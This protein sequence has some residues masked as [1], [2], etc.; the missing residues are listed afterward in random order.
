M[1]EHPDF[2]EIDLDP[3]PGPAASVRREPEK[4]SSTPREAPLDDPAADSESE[5]KLA[6]EIEPKAAPASIPSTVESPESLANEAE[7][8]GEAAEPPPKRPAGPPKYLPRITYNE[9]ANP[10]ANVESKNVDSSSAVKAKSDRVEDEKPSVSKK[11]SKSRNDVDPS[12]DGEKK[13]IEATPMI[14]TVEGRRYLRIAVG[15]GL[16]AVLALVILIIVKAAS[17]DDPK[18][19]IAAKSSD[20]GR[21]IADVVADKNRLNIEAKSMYTHAEEVFSRGKEDEAISLL[22]KIVKSYPDTSA[23]ADASKALERR[24]Q[25]MPIFFKGPIVS[26]DRETRGAALPVERA[27]GDDD[28]AAID[29]PPAIVANPSEIPSTNEHTDIQVA[30]VTPKPRRVRISAPLPDAE[31][32]QETGLSLPSA[33]VEPIPLPPGFRRREES[34][35]HESGLPIEI[36]SVIDGASMMLIPGGVF[37]MGRNDGPPEERPA[38]KVRLDPYYIDQHEITIKQYKR[39]LADMARKGETQYILPEGIASNNDA[40]IVSV[41]AGEARAYAAWAGKKLPTEAQWEFAAR[42]TDGRPHPWGDSPADWRRPRPPKRID[43]V[44]SFPTDLSPY[45]VFDLAGNA[46]EWT[47]DW[48]D[49]KLYQQ[50][51]GK[52]LVNPIGAR[53][54]RD[55]ER[56]VKGGSKTY[57]ASWRAGIK[58]DSRIPY[59]GFRCVL[60]LGNGA[61]GGAAP[62]RGPGQPD[63]SNPPI[64]PGAR[65][66]PF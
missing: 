59:L 21:S 50:T 17:P 46:W 52:L 24:E 42:T 40:P 33:D 39:F 54:S 26:A 7:D 20:S 56:T 28:T 47:S 58:E 32:R 15:G 27:I 60:S 8:E 22:E 63:L 34:G 9:P 62:P 16:F 4:S 14:E 30:K 23:A 55:R 2:D 65:Q 10:A 41:T 51:K 44:M 12:I 3:E 66:V 53:G 45:G 61:A 49:A 43:P 5:F 35:V 64:G 48:F 57:D 29:H 25:G 11:R 31:P 19:A 1:S 38:R 18:P 37:P 13:P 36:V 6:D